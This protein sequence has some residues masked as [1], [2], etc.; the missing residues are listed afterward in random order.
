[1]DRLVDRGSSS[2]F[3]SGGFLRRECLGVLSF[4]SRFSAGDD[5]AVLVGFKV[6][7]KL[8]FWELSPF[9]LARRRDCFHVGC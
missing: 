2:E 5:D 8:F 7:T 3:S 6:A 9:W 1:L 4:F